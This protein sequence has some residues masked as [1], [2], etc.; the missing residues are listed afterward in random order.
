MLASVRDG[1]GAVRANPG[2]PLLVLLVNL[3]TAA[4]LAAP[5]AR[6]VEADLAHRDA[7]VDMMYGFDHGW[8][9]EWS[10]RQ[11]G[12]TRD[13]GPE[14][15]GSGFAARSL[16]LLQRGELPL[17]LFA[18]PRREGDP[19]VAT[20]DPV[21]LG[22][23]ALYLLVQALLAGGLLGVFRAPGGGWTFRG[24]LHGAG[25]YGGRLLR[26][27]LLAL[28]AASLLF[29]GDALLARGTDALAREAVSETAALAWSLTRLALLLLAL[30]FLHAV[31]SLAKVILVLEERTSAVLAFLSGL[32]FCLRHPLRVLGQYG[33]V[34]L[35]GL[36]LLAAWLLVDARLEVTGYRSQLVF[37]VAAEAFLLARIGLRLSLLAAQ[38]ALYRRL[39]A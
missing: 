8:W 13:L 39:A 38:V 31:S 4:L 24:L 16:D 10:E 3:A 28:L 2:L 26:V 33:V 23:G 7:S 30:A 15:L 37:L 9:K 29:A 35:L 21:V 32:G 6:V 34:L 22:L 17:G 20:V 27:T 12:W 11:T 18:R 36:G 25:F 14:L 19:E 5:L 1:F